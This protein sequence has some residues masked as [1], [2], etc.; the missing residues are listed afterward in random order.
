M[1]QS[2]TPDLM[3]LSRRSVRR[4]NRGDVA[5]RGLRLGQPRSEQ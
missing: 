5:A 1:L 3:E 2:M 4:I